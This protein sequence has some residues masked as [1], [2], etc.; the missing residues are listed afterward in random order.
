MVLIVGCDF[1]DREPATFFEVGVGGTPGK[2]H[3]RLLLSKIRCSQD[4]KDYTML[5]HLLLK[6]RVES[7]EEIRRMVH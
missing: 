5:L 3:P 1:G 7:R 2:L 6:H 4:A